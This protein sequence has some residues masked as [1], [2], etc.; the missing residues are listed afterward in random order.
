MP[1]MTGAELAR[2]I[3]ASFLRL[4]VILASGYAELP[5]DDALSRFLRLTKPFTQ[6]Q[7]RTAVEHAIARHGIG[8]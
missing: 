5:N 8:A 2:L 4:P 3:F 1:G 7:L 6:E